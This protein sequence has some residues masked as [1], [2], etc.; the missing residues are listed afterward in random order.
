MA[1]IPIDRPPDWRGVRV[2]DHVDES[3]LVRKY[4]RE[5]ND[6][7]IITAVEYRLLGSDLIVHR[8]VNV[9]LKKWPAGMA[10]ALQSL[11]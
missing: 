10:G 7:E 8:S 11:G 9:Q 5:E 3:L 1:L 4:V 6:D 2:R